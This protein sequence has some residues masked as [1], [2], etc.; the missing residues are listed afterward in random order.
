MGAERLHG[1]LAV[2]GP[3][4]TGKSTVARRLARELNAAYLDTGSMY[5]AVTLAVL[6]AGR[7]PEAPEAADVALDASIEVGTDP[8]A[9]SILLGGED[10]AEEIRG[11]AVTTSVS[12]VSAYPQVRRRLVELQRSIIAEQ[13]G[14]GPGG[15]VVEGR[16]IG[17]VVAPSAPLKV[18]LTA[19]AEVRATRR[20][21]QDRRAGRSVDPDA[22][23]LAVRRRDE[24]DS[25]RAE[26]PLRPAKDAVT[27][28]TSKLDVT[29]VLARLHDL[30][31]ERGLVEREVA[32]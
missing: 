15:I 8:S 28:D 25:G 9:P 32:G 13:L 20:G 31:S 27:L 1:V 29:A 30:A 19:S 24:L 22:T 5:R 26:S 16:D 11:E 17:T 6:R 18:Y 21:G 3:S 4:G 23:L 10:V 14:K 2:D 7:S 12:A